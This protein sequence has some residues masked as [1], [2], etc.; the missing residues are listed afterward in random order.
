MYHE[1]NDEVKIDFEV[2]DMLRLRPYK[3]C[4]AKH[5]VMWCKDEETFL[6]W[7]GNHFGSFPINEDVMNNKYFNDNGDCL[8]EDNFYPMTA[9]DESG[10]VGH[11][12]MR[13]LN[14]DYD[15]LR[16]GWVIIDDSKR[17]MGYGKKMLSLGL[18][19]AFDMLKV[20]KVTIGVFENNVS[21]YWCYKNVGFNE[22]VMNQDEYDMINGEKWKIIELEITKAD[23]QSRNY[24]MQN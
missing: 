1:I 14:G 17:G 2:P 20:S 12:I 9:F 21:A 23:Y 11:F 10:V 7:G 3:K 22:A 6:K 18:K 15:I 13:Y 4:D 19:Y 24:A 16:F 8:E 5:I